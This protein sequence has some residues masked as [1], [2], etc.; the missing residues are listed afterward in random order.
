MKFLFTVVL[1][2]V[3]LTFESVVVRYLG[4][5]VTRIDVTVAL[6]VFLALRAG[7]IEGAVSSFSVGYLLD[8]MSGNP[9][10][11]YPFLAVL[12]FLVARL[13]AALVDA[14]SPVAYV[15]FVAG[16]DL[17]HGLLAA[18]FTWLTSKE[19]QVPTA[20]LSGLPLQVAL[21]VG[22]AILLWPLLRRFESAQDR[23][24]PGLLR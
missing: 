20:S 2:L 24:A 5:A 8:V 18:F 9:T 22:A 4:L 17:G 7:T 12:V 16:A 13:G 19:G 6:V 15:T 23:P 11:L 10:G 21:T 14:K 3:L 1:G